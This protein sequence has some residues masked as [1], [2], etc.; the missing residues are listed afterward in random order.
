MT[1]DMRHLGQSKSSTGQVNQFNI[2]YSDIINGGTVSG[3]ANK[4][5]T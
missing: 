2:E 4:M 5:L 1:E 3:R